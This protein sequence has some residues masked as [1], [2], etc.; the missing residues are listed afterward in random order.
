MI[1]KL[2]SSVLH[3]LTPGKILVAVL[4]FAAIANQ[5]GAVPVTVQEVGIGS[6]EIVQMTSSTLGTASVYA[7]TVN[8]LIN[9]QATQGFC[10]DPFHWSIGGPQPYNSEPLA[11]GPKAPV[12]GMGSAKA[13]EIEQLWG[14]Y[15]SPNIS[16]ENA[17]GLQI[18]IWE[19]VGGSDFQLKS[20]IDYGASD[21]LAWVNSH[22]DAPVVSLIAVTGPGQD[23]VIPCVPDSG[24]TAALLSMGLAGIGLMRSKFAKKV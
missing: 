14:Q 7:G 1:K 18:A 5:A 22:Q 15:Y 17:A 11:L 3:G 4:G 6:H 9:G 20:G 21:M 19:I 12:S 10:I 8:L 23:Y 24:E 13:T 2:Y 16:N